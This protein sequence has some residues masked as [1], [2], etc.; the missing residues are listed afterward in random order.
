MS[1]TETE[2][3]GTVRK[4]AAKI[5]TGGTRDDAA[6]TKGRARIGFQDKS[7]QWGQREFK[8]GNREKNRPRDAPA[9]SRIGRECGRLEKALQ[10]G[11]EI[12]KKKGRRGKRRIFGIWCGQHQT[13]T[14]VPCKNGIE[15]KIQPRAMGWGNTPSG[16]AKRKTKD[17][18]GDGSYNPTEWR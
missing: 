6:K 3:A 18:G 15:G 4:K 7:D 5:G 16:F 17:H 1:R 12:S 9:M 2:K 8:K 13:L 11:P 14:S 10:N